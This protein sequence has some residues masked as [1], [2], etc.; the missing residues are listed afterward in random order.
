MARKMCDIRVNDILYANSS[1]NPFQFLSCP[2][3]M[4]FFFF[5]LSP[6]PRG[7]RVKRSWDYN[8]CPKE[9]I[10]EAQNDQGTYP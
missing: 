9:G 3:N 7:Y 2:F 5:T 6:Y 8:P 4:V 1:L 10:S